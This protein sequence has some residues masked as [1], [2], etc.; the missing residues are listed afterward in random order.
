MKHKCDSCKYKGEHQ[1]MG[2]KI[3]WVCTK[4]HDRLKAMRAYMATECP[5]AKKGRIRALLS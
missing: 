3:S 2:F 1:E 4:E 5:F